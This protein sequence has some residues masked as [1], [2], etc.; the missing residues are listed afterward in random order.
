[1]NWLIDWQAISVQIKGLLDAGSFF[2]SALHNSSVDSCSVKK[3]VLLPN[4]EKIVSN[5]K[6][7]SE[8]YKSAFPKVAVECLNRFMDKPEM[9]VSGFFKPDESLEAGNVQFALTSLAA[10]QSEFNYLIADTEL[11]ARRLTERAFIHLQRSIVVDEA[12]R[13]KWKTAFKTRETKCEELGALHLLS[14]GVWAFKADA[15]GGRTDLILNEPLTLTDIERTADA[16][17]LTEWK[18][19]KTQSELNAKIQ[20]AQRQAEIYSS[21]VLGGM[22]LRNYRYLIMV[23]ENRL[24][25]PTDIIKGVTK[26]RHINIAVDPGSPSVEAKNLNNK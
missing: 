10:F 11:I 3:K 6:N 8:K 7:F 9:K 13:E 26:Y 25:M 2:Y 4:A 18:L 14:H 23:S 24:E 19:V 22:E 20:E 12:I 1:M 5:L 16:L 21:D 15:T 17:V